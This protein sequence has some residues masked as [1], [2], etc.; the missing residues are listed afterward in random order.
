MRGLEVAVDVRASAIAPTAPQPIA[1]LRGADDAQLV[2]RVA[3]HIYIGDKIRGD[4]PRLHR[5]VP[6]S[7][8]CAKYGSTG[9]LPASAPVHA[10]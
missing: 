7:P 4:S 6:L 9:R 8:S 10:S 1:F 2:V 5:Q 3:E